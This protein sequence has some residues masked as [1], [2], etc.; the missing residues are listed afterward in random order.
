MCLCCLAF[1]PTV[2]LSTLLTC[3]KQIF[4]APACSALKT[5]ELVCI[6]SYYFSREQMAE[7][8]SCTLL[9]FYPAILNV[10]ATYIIGSNV[11]RRGEY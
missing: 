9:S 8:I 2:F 7:P 11:Q 4:P 10:F 6:L 3:F 1:F 5:Y